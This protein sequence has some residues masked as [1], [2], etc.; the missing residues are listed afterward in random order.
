MCLCAKTEHPDEENRSIFIHKKLFNFY[1]SC[2]LS[3][4]TTRGSFFLVLSML[5]LK[6]G[7]W[8]SDIMKSV[9]D[10]IDLISIHIIRCK[11]LVFFLLFGLPAAVV[12]VV[13]GCALYFVYFS[14]TSSPICLCRVLYIL[15]RLV[16]NSEYIN[17]T[18]QKQK[19]Q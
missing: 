14:S 5:P 18:L 15:Y 9:C 17:K 16:I 4:G 2:Y 7:V 8:T 13:V 10:S 1:Y 12:I 19:Q 11:C 3:F 6:L